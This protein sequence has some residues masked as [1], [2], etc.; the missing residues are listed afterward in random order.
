MQVATI[1]CIVMTLDGS[2]YGIAYG[3]PPPPLSTTS[4]AGDDRPRRLR[5]TSTI[6]SGDTAATNPSVGKHHQIYGNPHFSNDEIW[7]RGE[8]P[9]KDNNRTN[10]QQQLEETGDG[11]GDSFFV[12]WR[13]IALASQFQVVLIFRHSR[14]YEN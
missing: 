9:R 2:H 12:Q 4:A 14:I 10:R 7:R 6:Q 3:G 13:V 5:R 11:G 8:T 1:S